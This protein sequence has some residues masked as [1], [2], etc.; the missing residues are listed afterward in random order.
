MAL[1]KK[2]AQ[3]R[4]V[5]LGAA[6]AALFALTTA[7]PALASANVRG[8]VFTFTSPAGV[9]EHCVMLVRMPGAV[10][11]ESDVAEEKAFCAIDLH[12]RTHA[13]C[14]KL[15]STSPGTLIYLL[16]GGPYGDNPA[17]FERDVCPRGHVV[18][19]EAADEPISLKMSVNARETSATFA[20]S[21]L[22]YYHFARYFDAAVHVPPAVLRSIDKDSHLAR[23]ASQGE[24]LSSGRPA[25]KMN[26]AAWAT[27]AK[28]ERDPS[29]YQPADELFTADRTQVYGVILHPRG[30]RYGDEMNGSRQSGWGDGQSRDFQQTPP[31]VA[32]A[33]DRPLLE[34]IDEGMARGYMRTAVPAA[35]RN[36]QM[37][38]WM[39]A[40]VD[41]TLLDYIFSQQDR[42]GNIDYLTY[43]YW[44]Q[45]GEVRRTPAQGVHPPDE[46]AKFSPKLLKRTELADNDAGVRTSYIN[47]AKRTGMLERIRHYPAGTYRRLMALDK[48]FAARGPLHE[49]IR[50]TFGLSDAE[51][52]Q[53]VANTHSAS[54]ILRESC[55]AGRLRFDLEPEA[56]LRDGKVVEAKV[57]CDNP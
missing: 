26:H 13:M 25:L 38:F 14:P 48:D 32:L 34:A 22:I 3:Q 39:R 44:V 15:F 40:L 49:H 6:A 16:A 37:A 33:T 35:A 55:R 19:K 21:S 51:F 1:P 24:S 23:V 29:S 56:L 57:D 11:R 54:A 43:W 4:R 30:R 47:Y 27:L 20:N 7:G 45:N 36:E 31:F 2:G 41:I 18:E 52:A 42:I 5:R 9:Q 28:A 53:A 46:I 50:S 8:E 10:Y 17:G 12:G